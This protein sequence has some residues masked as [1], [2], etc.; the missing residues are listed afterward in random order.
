MLQVFLIIFFIGDSTQDSNVKPEILANHDQHSAYLE[1]VTKNKLRKIIMCL[2][3][4][5]MKR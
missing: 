1:P 2:K 3:A 5:K 4:D